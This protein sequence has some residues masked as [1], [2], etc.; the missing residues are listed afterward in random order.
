MRVLAPT[1]DVLARKR[2]AV[3]EFRTQI[4]P[5]SEDP[6]DATILPPWVLA[7]LM[8]TTERVLW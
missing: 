7:R 2:R 5:L 6:R 8:R 3:D 4:R 1:V